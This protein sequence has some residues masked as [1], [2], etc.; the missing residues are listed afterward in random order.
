MSSIPSGDARL[1]TSRGERMGNW[2]WTLVW[3][4]VRKS[5][6]PLHS[7]IWAVRKKDPLPII[8]FCRQYKPLYA[9]NIAYWIL[10]TNSVTVKS[11]FSTS[12]KD[13]WSFTHCSPKTW[14]RGGGGGGAGFIY[15]R[16]KHKTDRYISRPDKGDHSGCTPVPISI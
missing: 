7:Y 9:R 16:M 1:S 3:T 4:W 5:R 11:Y 13:I 12:V 10:F 2:A 14:G 8:Y 15:L 6:N